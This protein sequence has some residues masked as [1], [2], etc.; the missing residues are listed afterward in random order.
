MLCAAAISAGATISSTALAPAATSSGTGA[1]A[2]SMLGKW[3]QETVVR[4]RQGTV[5]NTASAMN[6]ERALGAD[7]QAAEDLQRLSASRKAQSR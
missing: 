6:A 2:A 4:A 1:I 7:Q 5:S 3:S